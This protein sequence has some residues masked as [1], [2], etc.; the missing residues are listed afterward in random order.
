MSSVSGHVGGDGV[1]GLCPQRAVLALMRGGRGGCRDVGRTG[2]TS[3]LCRKGLK[4]DVGW[5]SGEVSR[6]K[7]VARLRS[8]GGM[9]I[10]TE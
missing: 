8:E 10:E 2:Q 9:V 3:C 6:R 5:D 1:Q 7:F 4:P